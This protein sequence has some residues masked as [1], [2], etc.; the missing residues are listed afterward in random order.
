MF[1]E[2]RKKK[3]FNWKQNTMKEGMKT[4]GSA[5]AG[6]K[7]QSQIHENGI[8]FKLHSIGKTCPN[9]KHGE[10]L[11]KENEKLT[12]NVNFLHILW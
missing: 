10:L 11:R 1:S 9:P 6:I 4:N 2:K 8:F 7:S 12:V 3:F 5:A